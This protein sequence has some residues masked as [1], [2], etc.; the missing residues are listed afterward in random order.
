MDFG[1]ILDQ[2]E[3][4]EKISAKKKIQS[5]SGKKTNAPEKTVK[6]VKKNTDMNAWLNKYG[7]VDKDSL[8]KEYKITKASQSHTSAK[9]LPIDATID[10][11]NFTQ[12]AAWQHLESFIKT[13]KAKGLKKV[14]IIH[15]KGTHSQGDPV[16]GRMV[17]LF[18]EQS[19]MLGASGHPKAVLGGSGATWA[20][21]K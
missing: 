19:S 1:D 9:N 6:Q 10:L 14:L 15:G 21:I 20:V 11:H 7:V 2:W 4:G 5:G 8:V 17:R 12:E 3:K 16:L 18:I 13:C